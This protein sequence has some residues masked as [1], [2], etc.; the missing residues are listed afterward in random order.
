[1]THVCHI[2]SV[3][4]QDD[5]RIFLKECRSLSH[6]FKVSLIVANGS[7]AIVEDV[8][9][10]GVPVNYSGRIQRFIKAVD[11]VYKEAIKVRADVYHLH[12]PE[13]L[14]IAIKLRKGG[15][16]V[17]YDAH[18]DLPRQILSKPWIPAGFRHLMSFIVEKL[19]N[20]VLKR[21]DGVVTATPYIKDRIIK[22]NHNTIDIN[23]FPLESEIDDDKGEKT[24]DPG[25]IC[26]IGGLSRIRGIKELIQSLEYV[27]NIELFLAGSFSEPEFEKECKELPSWSKVR[28]MGFI[29]REDSLKLKEKC[30]AGVVTFLPVENHVN[31]QPN[32]IFEYMSARLPVIGSDFPMW[33]DL[34]AKN[35]VGLCVD[36]SSPRAIANAINFLK[37]N[38]SKAKEYGIKGNL[39]VRET[40]NWKVEEKKLVDFY[41]TVLSEKS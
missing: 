11:A 5:I 2:T 13:L 39:L 16:K 9:I 33:K 27:D 29:S 8:N 41:H 14:R 18:E 1:M 32:K 35:E 38:P 7:S 24:L 36:P 20:G 3:H 31:A 12:D 34:I 17:I 25:M 4:K 19:E 37:E 23:N 40:F 6:Q 22:V 21:L 30:L 26:Y 15:A 10:V 28:E